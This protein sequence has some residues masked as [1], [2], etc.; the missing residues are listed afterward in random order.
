MIYQI[1]PRSAVIVPATAPRSL[2][3][4]V[5]TLVFRRTR[6]EEQWTTVINQGGEFE[7]RV[8]GYA[9]LLLAIDGP[10]AGVQQ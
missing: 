3:S 4:P 8:P 1:Y 7:G 9:A 5:G 10:A 2:D 6:R